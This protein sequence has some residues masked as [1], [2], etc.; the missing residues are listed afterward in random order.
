M[1]EKIIFRVVVTLLVGVLVAT[2]LWLIFP[3][4]EEAEVDYTVETLKQSV[5]SLRKK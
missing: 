1:K 4:W 3:T 5:A 2:A